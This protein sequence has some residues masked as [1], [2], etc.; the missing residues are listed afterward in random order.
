MELQNEGDGVDLLLDQ[1]GNGV[2]LNIDSEATSKVLINLLPINGNT[3]GDISCNGTGR[4]SDPST[5]S[6]GDIWYNGTDARWKGTLSGNDRTILG[7]VGPSFDA[8]T[9]TSTISTGSVSALRGTI[10]L[11]AETGTAD[12]LDTLNVVGSSV[13][14]GD[15]IILR[16]DTGDTI[17]VKH[18]T[19]NIHLDASA[20]KA[21]VNGNQLM[22]IYNGTDWLQLTPMMVLP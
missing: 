4:T 10:V 21:L 17:T 15:T 3:R 19:G 1:N 20:D 11:A 5:P 2:A 16:A 7:I 13:Q 8:S 6:N 14:D 22:L 9:F 18:N 12:D